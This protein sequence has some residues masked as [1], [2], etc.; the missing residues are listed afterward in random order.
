[1][2]KG[3]AGSPADPARL[4]KE[5]DMAFATRILLFC[6]G[7]MF[8]TLPADV[9]G[10]TTRLAA[11]GGAGDY[12]E[13]VSNVLRWY[14]SLCDYRDAVI[15]DLG[16]LEGG[17][18]A[19]LR[20]AARQGA[21]LHY[22]LDRGG[23]WGT[24]AVYVHDA[25]DTSRTPGD[26]ELLWSRSWGK[27]QTGF[28]YSSYG[29]TRLAGASGDKVEPNLWDQTLGLGLRLNVSTKLYLDGAGE[30]TRTD[31]QYI[32]PA[33]QQ[34]AS[35]S[36]AAWK[37]F[38]L[39]VR[40]FWGMGESVAFVPVATHRK[41]DHLDS[42][43]QG[44]VLGERD[45]RATTLGGAVSVFPDSDNMLFGAWEYRWLK[46]DRAGVT[47][48]SAS[49]STSELTSDGY[50]LRL[51][52]ES[53]VCSWLTFRAGARQTVLTERRSSSELKTSNRV[54]AGVAGGEG[55]IE[56]KEPTLDLAVGLALHFG[57]LSADFVFNDDAPFS[58]GH[59]LTGAGEGE[60]H[61]FSSISLSYTF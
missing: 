20:A 46:R 12:L 24:I 54:V 27:V 22:G 56:I 35:W 34:R 10:T 36:E 61:T 55:S 4:L 18:E 26:L 17:E 32:W 60:S 57:A 11:L 40:A 28:F 1:L 13:D 37:S 25:A 19:S 44:L 59:F 48:P 14:G 49:P 50:V 23:T 42:W 7:A 5:T 8:V 2:N 31:R 6:L 15:I 9:G 53:R 38:A 51:G 47:P 58:F 41:D 21:G 39:R 29:R 30:W 33:S 52:M 16:V 43:R 45:E 3:G